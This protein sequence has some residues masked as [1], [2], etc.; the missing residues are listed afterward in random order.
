MT[1]SLFLP[2]G[3]CALLRVSPDEPG[4]LRHLH[5][6]GRVAFTGARSSQDLCGQPAGQAQPRMFGGRRKP[7]VHP[8]I[9]L[10]LQGGLKYSADILT[11]LQ[12]M[13]RLGFFPLQSRAAPAGVPGQ[14]PTEK[15]QNPG[16]GRGNGCRRPGDRHTHPVNDPHTVWR[17]H[18]SDNRSPPQ[19]HHGLHQVCRSNILSGISIRPSPLNWM[20]FVFPPHLNDLQSYSQTK[21]I[22][23]DSKSLQ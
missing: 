12:L 13:W 15:N 9:M 7:Q 14:G 19:H 5:R 11:K 4:P 8:G 17:L 2:L 3:P 22:I 10:F 20:N 18:C 21:G 1:R 6:W 23:S 16:S